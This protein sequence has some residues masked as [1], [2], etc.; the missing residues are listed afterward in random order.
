MKASKTHLLQRLELA[1]FMLGAE[2]NPLELNYS[3][4]YGGWQLTS[5]DGSH[6]EY[7][8]TSAKE[9]LAFIDGLIKSDELYTEF[10][11]EK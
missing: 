7:H 10:T 1:N 9:M 6:I 3:S 4:A 2:G 8:R 5:K 11:K